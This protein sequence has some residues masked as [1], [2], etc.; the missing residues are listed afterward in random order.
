[1]S[2]I[3]GSY[4]YDPE[5]EVRPLQELSWEK[6]GLQYSEE[7]NVPKGCVMIHIFSTTKVF[8]SWAMAD[9]WLRWLLVNHYCSLMYFLFDY[10]TSSPKEEVDQLPMFTVYAPDV[11]MDQAPPL[12]RQLMNTH[13]KVCRAN[14]PRIWIQCSDTTTIAQDWDEV[15]QIIMKR[16]AHTMGALFDTYT[17]L[18]DLYTQKLLTSPNLPKNTNEY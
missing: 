7:L 15:I 1:M 18:V 3:V 9:A 14:C 8:E 5:L 4:N 2:T 11:L 10:P 13:I 12:L 17:R 6:A 16:T